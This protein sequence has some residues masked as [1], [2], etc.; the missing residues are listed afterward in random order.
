M[1]RNTFSN[2]SRKNEVFLDDKS[3][4]VAFNKMISCNDTSQILMYDPSHQKRPEKN[5]K[6]KIEGKYYDPFKDDFISFNAVIKSNNKNG[7][8]FVSTIPLE[9]ESPVLIRRKTPRNN[10]RKN[11]F[12]ESNHA[13]VITCRQI[14]D[15]CNEVQYEINIEFF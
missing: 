14:P 1:G 7:L 15:T 3:K 4:L 12:A 6:D 8:T 13:Q 11:N 5:F 2:L 10:C 9:L